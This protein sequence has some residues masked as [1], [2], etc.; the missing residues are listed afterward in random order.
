MSLNT[1]QNT[2]VPQAL[3]LPALILQA[4]I[5]QALTHLALVLIHPAH[6]PLVP[7]AQ[8]AHPLILLPQREITIPRSLIMNQLPPRQLLNM[9]LQPLR[10][11]SISLNS[12]EFH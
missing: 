6:P 8:E 10:L 1:N 2:K 7:R 9:V 11:K 12:I 4:L 3:V 5:L